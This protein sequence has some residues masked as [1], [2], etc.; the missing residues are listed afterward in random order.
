LPADIVAAVERKRLQNTLS[1]RKSRAR[2]HA[3]LQELETENEALRARI[4]ELEARLAQPQ[5]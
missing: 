4:A 5:V 1:A 2:K 3:R